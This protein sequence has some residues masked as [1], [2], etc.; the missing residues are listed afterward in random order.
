MEENDFPFRRIH[1][2]MSRL[3][4]NFSFQVLGSRGDREKQ[5]ERDTDE[6]IR[7]IEKSV[8][9]N[10]QDALTKLLEMVYD[11]KP[12]LHVNLRL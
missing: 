4:V 10:K 9:R 1:V 5:I 12:E 8:Q 7:S 11:I 3:K 6:K 2:C